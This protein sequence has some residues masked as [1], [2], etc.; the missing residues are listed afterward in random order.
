MSADQRIADEVADGRDR[1]TFNRPQK[2][3]ALSI[4]R[5]C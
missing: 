2:R 4:A 5:R 3:N 1:I